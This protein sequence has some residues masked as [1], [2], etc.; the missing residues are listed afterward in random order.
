MKSH[1]I[2]ENWIVESWLF[3]PKQHFL[4][5]NSLNTQSD[6]AIAFGDPDG[7]HIVVPQRDDPTHSARG[8]EHLFRHYH[9]RR[10]KWPDLPIARSSRQPRNRLR[11]TP[12][13][14]GT[15]TP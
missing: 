13:T 10:S 15:L 8:V 12:S 14:P 2:V 9:F 7:G 11:P 3:Q 4:H 1:S 6:G 5:N